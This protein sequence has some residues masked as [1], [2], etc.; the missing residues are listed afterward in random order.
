LN[1]QKVGQ[2]LDDLRSRIEYLEA[3]MQEMRDILSTL[4][5]DS[6]IVQVDK[7]AMLTTLE[8]KSTKEPEVVVKRKVYDKTIQELLDESQGKG[9]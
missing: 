3:K 5:G 2:D 7:D 4:L 9:R 6:T 8:S 1:L